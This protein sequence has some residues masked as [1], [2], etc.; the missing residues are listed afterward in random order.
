MKHDTQPTYDT[1][2]LNSIALLPKALPLM[3][4]YT[5]VNCFLDN[6]AGGDTAMD[7]IK[8]GFS[9]KIVDYRTKYA[10]FKDLSEWFEALQEDKS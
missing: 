7:G 10:C 6:D 1:L 3:E 4:K 9:G 5:R 2:I 8:A